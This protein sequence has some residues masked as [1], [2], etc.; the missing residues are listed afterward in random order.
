VRFF[1]LKNGSVPFNARELQVR[2]RNLIDQ[3][4]NLRELFSNN[5]SLDPKEITANSLDEKFLKEFLSLLE[6]RYHN[7]DFG[8]PQMQK[9]LAMSKTQL[10][11][12]VKTLTNHPPGELL[13]IFRLKR[14]AQLLSKKAGNISQI[15]YD[16]GFNSLS[17]FTK[18]FKEQFGSSPSEYMQDLND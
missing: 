2:T 16:T 18:C 11:T 7:A 12:K 3:R 17:H 1:L 4:R 5:M 15:A 9:E 13:R 8:V 14:A 6:K 10:H